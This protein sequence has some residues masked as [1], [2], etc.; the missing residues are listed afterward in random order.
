[1]TNKRFSSLYEVYKLSVEIAGEYNVGFK[2]SLLLF[3]ISFVTLGLAFAMFFPL[4]KAIFSSQADINEI[5]YWFSFMAFF[6]L[7]SIVTKWFGHNLRVKLGK[8]LRSMP[9]HTLSKYKTGELNSIL[10]SNVDES[11]LHMGV[12]SALFMQ[13]TVVPIVVVL[14]TFFIDYKIKRKV[15]IEEKK[16]FNDA[17]SNLESQLIEYIQG[18]PVLR[19]VNQVG[20]NAKQLD[21][22]VKK[23][24]TIQEEGASKSTLPLLI[25]GSL[26]E[27]VLLVLVF[28]GGMWVE[29][30]SLALITLAALLV[31]VS[32]LTEPLTLFLG[33]IPVF[34]TMDS[35]FNRI[36]TVLDIKS[37][38]TFEPKQKA[39]SFDIEFENVF[40]SYDKDETYSLKNISF[41]IKQNSLT[42]IVGHSGCGK[43][44]ITKML[45]RYDDVSKGSVKIGGVNIKNMTQKELMKDISVVFQ[46]VYLFDDTVLNNI[47][48]A[49]PKAT[50]DEIIKACKLANCHDFIQNLP[51]SYETNIGDLGGNLSGGESLVKNRTVIVIAHR[52]STITHADNILVMSEGEIIQQGKHEQILVLSEIYKSMW[53][54]QTRTKNWN[55]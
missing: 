9:L 35:A 55:T 45:M 42:A 17:N 30:G 12:V 2:R 51:N 26:V 41:N 1:M 23:V 24:R 37:L 39:K 27:I 38:K 47:K 16:D 22:A 33:V 25:M 31:V 8:K 53:E 32:R 34:D 6:S 21:L 52:L 10:S 36:K 7:I 3:F 4:L 48:M 28:L 50:K 18:L 54:A 14:F 20:K 11:I 44:T 29:E 15:S 40:Y 43:T 19:S 49:K 13:I 5:I 46:D